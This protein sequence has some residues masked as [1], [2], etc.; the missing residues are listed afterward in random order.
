M[1]YVSLT[2]VP[3]R[4]QFQESFEK[5]L[6]ALLNQDTTE[7]YKVVLN[8]P[9]VYTNYGS[10]DLPDWLIDFEKLYTEKLIILRTDVDFGPITNLVYPVKLLDMDPDDVIII[11]D[12]DH[13]YEASMISYH[14]KKL[15]EYPDNH[16]ICF[17]G[18]QPL[19]LRTWYDNGKRMGVL[20]GTHFYFPLKHDMYLRFPDHWHTVSYK[21][22]F[23]KD[24]LMDSEFLSMTWNNDQLLAHYAWT[25]DFY[26]VCAA[27]DEETDFRPVNQ[28]G[29]ASHSFPIKNQL[30]YNGDSGCNLYRQKTDNDEVWKNEKFKKVFVDKPPSI[31]GESN[32]IEK[33]IDT[34]SQ[35]VV[36][37]V[38]QTDTVVVTLT[39]VP[40]RLADKNGENA[41]IRPG[42]KTIL[43]QSNVLYE[44]HLN[45][46]YSY[47]YKQI[48]LPEWL[49]AWQEKYKHLKIFRCPDFGPI[50]KIYP[51]IQRIT[52][53]NTVL[54][55]VDD[56]LLYEDGFII[57]H[58]NKMKQHPGCA[59]GFAGITSIE[60]DIVGRYHF[61]STQ[62]EDIRVRMLE[63]YKTVS[64][65]RYFFTD[66]LDQF[67]FSHWNDDVALSAYLGYKNIKKIALT[68]ENCT[69]FT[70]R[71]ES[72]PIIRHAPIHSSGCNVFRRNDDVVLDGE[73]VANEWYK[74]GYLER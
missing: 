35:S 21:R 45:I 39:S 49:G 4:M 34:P 14:V 5:C 6:I 60:P 40:D 43:E 42:L 13:E 22:K 67:V 10:A 7:K 61:A 47:Q 38:D 50:T 46:P 9:T 8:I 25:H 19:D 56:D 74:L 57:A 37:R 48:Q 29:R 51:T 1:I 24:D 16:A 32:I 12:D 62:P 17:R 2:T 73:K 63:G 69:D 3:D 30:P 31:W 52:D 55:T 65:R 18:N 53:P 44:V 11:C 15:K 66:E 71:V 36:Q 27:Y 28:Y 70:P 58:L 20:L 59:L 23:F 64:Y 26:F 41:G 68:C 33:V 54:I 72:F